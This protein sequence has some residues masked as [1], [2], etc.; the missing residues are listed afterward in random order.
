MTACTRPNE[1]RLAR[2]IPKCET[3]DACYK[4]LDT[5]NRTCATVHA[6]GIRGYTLEAER[7]IRAAAF[8]RMEEIRASEREARDAEIARLREIE[9]ERYAREWWRR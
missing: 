2:R 9:R 4:V 3:V 5:L 7:E 8:A 1:R 6:D